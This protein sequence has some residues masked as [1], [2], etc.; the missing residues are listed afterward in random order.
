MAAATTRNIAVLLVNFRGDTRQPWTRTYVDGVFFT[1]PGS[2]AAYFE[3]GSYGKVDVTGRVVD[4]LTIDV[5][6]STCAYYTWSSAA[7]AAAAAKGVDLAAFTNIVYAFPS[8]SICSWS[9]LGQTPGTYSWLNG[10]MSLRLAAHELTH[11]FGAHHASSLSCTNSSGVRVAISTTCTR[12]EYGDPFAVMGKAATRHQHN[13]HRMRLGWIPSTAV[14]TVSLNGSYTITPASSVA[15]S[16]KVVRVLRADGTYLYLEFRQPYGSYFDAFPSLD[17]A[18]RGVTVRIAPETGLVRSKLVDTTPATTSFLD[19]PL[20]VGKTLL[21]TP[22]KVTVTTTAVSIAG[23]TVQ[24]VI[25]S[26]TDTL[27]PTAPTNLVAKPTGATTASVTWTAST[28]NVKVAGYRVYRNGVLVS[29][30]TGTSHDATGLTP[31]STYTYKVVAFDP[32]NNVSAA[33]TTLVMPVVDVTAPTA[34]SSLGVAASGPGSTVVTWTASTDNVTVAGYRVYRDGNLVTTT[35]ATSATDSGLASGTSY[36]YSVTAFDAAGNASPPATTTFVMPDLVAP[37][38][39]GEVRAEATG[40]T[41]ASVSWTRATDD[42]TVTGY[43]VYRDGMLLGTTTDLAWV[44][45]AAVPG[46]TY[47][48]GVSERDGAGNAGPLV[49]TTLT[50]PI[51]DTTPPAAPTRVEAEQKG[52]NKVRVRWVAPPDGDLASYEVFRDGTRIATAR[53]TEYFDTL[54]SGTATYHVVAVDRAGNRSAASESVSITVVK[55]R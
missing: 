11:N 14:K 49:S 39:V 51:P 9:A 27:P 32:A 1:N 12:S 18:V 43:A 53:D 20:M 17:P 52:Q 45:A 13:W 54:S 5:D 26:A 44:D 37:S 22:G 7:R 40:A 41:T 3:E 21:D 6:R 36:G 33:S 42:V 24:I 29:T 31:G 50:M 30:T 55:R 19:A 35:T 8:Q 4:W 46:A 23:A 15:G 16:P 28:D 2:V 25:G 34:P 47:L 48:Y 10:A 38:A